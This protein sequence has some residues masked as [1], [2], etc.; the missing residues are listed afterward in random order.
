MGWFRRHKTRRAAQRLHR[1]IL[2][3]ARDPQP[4]QDG[5]VPDTLEG[6]FHMVTLIAAITIRSLRAG[7]ETSSALIERLNDEI[8]SG[9]DHALRE[10][11][12]GDSS[13][14]RRI[15]KMGETY[16]GLARA[17]DTA[18]ESENVPRELANVLSRNGVT[19][20]AQASDLAALLMAFA[21]QMAKHGPAQG[22]VAEAV[23]L[24]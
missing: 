3:K 21:N 7:G 4:F 19:K 16:V 17:V 12:V 13:I 1:A 9:F 20:P 23:R 11:G 5:L 22:L 24:S 15:R 2:R 6:R 10:E 8:F 14:A 18:L